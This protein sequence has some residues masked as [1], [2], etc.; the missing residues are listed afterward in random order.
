MFNVISIISWFAASEG[1][2]NDECA[3]GDVCVKSGPKL[4][5]AS[6]FMLL[7]SVG[8]FLIIYCRRSEESLTF[9]EVD[10]KMRTSMSVSPVKI[11][12]VTPDDTQ[13]IK[14]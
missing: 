3:D 7:M 4:A 5:I 1:V 2:V 8:L 13:Y 10:L 9:E 12:N 11:S 6:N 14:N